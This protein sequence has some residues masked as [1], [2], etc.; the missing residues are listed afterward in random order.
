MLQFF[1]LE[2]AWPQVAETELS[3]GIPSDRSKTLNKS[4]TPFLKM[5]WNTESCLHGFAELVRAIALQSIR[6][7]MK[8]A[9][10]GMVLQS[11]FLKNYEHYLER[12]SR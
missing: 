7:M 4:L 10:K 9:C 5:N 1:D 12:Y 6:F 2:S 3:P 11:P 8:H